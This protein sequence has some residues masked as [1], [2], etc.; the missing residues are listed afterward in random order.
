MTSQE[1]K[2]PAQYY[3]VEKYLSEARKPSP[4]SMPRRAIRRLV[5]AF[6]PLQG[7]WLTFATFPLMILVPFGL[8]FLG[9]QYG[10]AAFYPAAIAGLGLGA[11][12]IEKKFGRH[13]QVEDFSLLKR[14]LMLAP[15]FLLV[16]AFFTLALYLAGRI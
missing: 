6:D 11:Y 13:I 16:L 12:L 3:N 15:A 4:G 5:D 7:F 8:L 1:K 9:L 10:P 14:T 2:D